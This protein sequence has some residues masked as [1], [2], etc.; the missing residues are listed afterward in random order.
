LRLFECE[1]AD[2]VGH[3][4]WEANVLARDAVRD[5]AGRLDAEGEVK[6]YELRGRT[7]KDRP[8]E[9]VFS[10]KVIP[11]AGEACTLSTAVDITDRKRAGE[12]IARQLDELRRWHE[13]TLGRED[14]IVALKAEVNELL[15]QLKQPAR[16]AIGEAP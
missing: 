13:A 15:A 5:I 11:L 16:Y 7:R 9:L 1:R 6:N 8:L 2:I 10:G 12:E 14:R 4:M 3:T